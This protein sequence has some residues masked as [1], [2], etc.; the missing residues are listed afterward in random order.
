MPSS[1]ISTIRYD[2]YTSVLTIIFVSG[3]V[4]NYRDVP[5]V[6]Y[7]AM[8]KAISKGTFFNKHIKDKYDFEKAE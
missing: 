2:A 8:K 5:E 1:V 3:A 7:Q 4:Y 6:I